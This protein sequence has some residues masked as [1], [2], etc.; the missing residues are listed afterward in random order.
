[1]QFNGSFPCTAYRWILSTNE[2]GNV[3]LMKQSIAKDETTALHNNVILYNCD[4]KF[5]H[6]SDGLFGII[7]ECPKTAKQNTL[8][9]H[10]LVEIKRLSSQINQLK[11]TYLRKVL[12]I[13]DLFRISRRFFVLE[14]GT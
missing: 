4:A 1:M 7:N 3:F 14:L 6:V 10:Y 12:L 11:S 13:W 8:R 9:K 5:C 2:F